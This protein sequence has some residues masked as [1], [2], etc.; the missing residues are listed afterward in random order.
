MPARERVAFNSILIGA[1]DR[2]AFRSLGQRDGS[3]YSIPRALK[4]KYA[5]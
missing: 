2:L 4:P 3:I 5:R 1:H